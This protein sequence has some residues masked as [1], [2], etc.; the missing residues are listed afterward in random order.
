[1]RI[2]EKID[3]GIQFDRQKFLAVVHYV[4]RRQKPS[5]MG[6]IKLHLVLYLA[7]MMHF[8]QDG[9]PLAGAEYERQIFG[10]K[11]K[12]LGWAV[13]ELQNQGRLQVKERDFF[14]VPKLDFIALGDG[15][16]GALSEDEMGLLDAVSDFVCVHNAKELSELSLRETWDCVEN[17]QVIP[18]FMAMSLV[19][20]EVTEADIEWAT[21][22]Y[23]RLQLANA[24]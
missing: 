12:Q 22:E 18:Y 19:P 9:H 8:L 15:S 14:G 2:T 23:R 1:M 21:Q 11:A 20:C 6:R 7:D 5:D 13:K 10:P 3:E 16:P 4:C 24:M 17:G